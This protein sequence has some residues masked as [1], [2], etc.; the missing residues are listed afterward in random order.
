MVAQGLLGSEEELGLEGSG[1]VRRVGSNVVDV[2]VDDKSPGNRI[3]AFSN[4][5]YYPC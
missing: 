4:L 1:V 2:K 3:W 5:S